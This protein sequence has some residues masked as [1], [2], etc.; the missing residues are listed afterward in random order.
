MNKDIMK[1]L[2]FSKEVNLVENNMCPMCS[3]TIDITKFR[4]KLSLKEYYISG[5]CQECQDAFI[6][7]I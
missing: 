6:I 2:G 5:L 3:K 4:D 7:A 1:K